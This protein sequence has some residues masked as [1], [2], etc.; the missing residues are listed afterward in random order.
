MFEEAVRL[1]PS[2]KPA[3]QALGRLY[4][5]TGRWADLAGLFEKELEREDEDP[6]GRVAKLF[7]LAELYESRLDRADDA[8]RLLSELLVLQSAYPPALKALERL[9]RKKERWTDLAALYERE[10]MLTDDT[11]QRIFCLLYTSRCV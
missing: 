1:L 4:E 3:F 5:R 2:Y 9:Y 6:S 8:I 10:A 11:D 7:K